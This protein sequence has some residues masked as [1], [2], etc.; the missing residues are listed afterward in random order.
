M[1]KM[2]AEQ[3]LEQLRLGNTEVDLINEQEYERLMDLVDKVY[4]TEGEDVAHHYIRLIGA[5][6]LDGYGEYDKRL[7]RHIED[8]ENEVVN[9]TRVILADDDIACYLSQFKHDSE[10]IMTVEQY[11]ELIHNAA[12]KNIGNVRIKKAEKVPAYIVKLKKL[13]V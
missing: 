3:V 10:F 1:T 6:G 7:E 8:M 13:D 11:E 5:A 9:A 4:D 12:G 2:T